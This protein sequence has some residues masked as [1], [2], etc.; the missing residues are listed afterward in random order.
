VQCSTYSL[1]SQPLGRRL[2]WHTPYDVTEYTVA[3]L[4][5]LCG[6]ARATIDGALGVNTPYGVRC[7]IYF[8][9]HLQG[10]NAVTDPSFFGVNT[11]PQQPYRRVESSLPVLES[12]L[13][14][15]QLMAFTL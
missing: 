15:S 7:I 9:K 2:D 3:V 5:V 12:S 13:P 6:P 14:Y 4:G 1:D 8:L 11:N 10:R